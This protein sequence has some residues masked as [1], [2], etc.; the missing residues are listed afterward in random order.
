MGR[1][2]YMTISKYE[3]TNDFY[4]EIKTNSL[5]R[6]FSES[7]QGLMETLY[8]GKFPRKTAE[9][10]IRLKSINSTTLLI[11]FLNEVLSM[12]HLYKE[13][14]KNIQILSL[15]ASEVEI[16]LIGCAVDHFDNDIRATSYL[17][18][19]TQVDGKGKW[20]SKFILDVGKTI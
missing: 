5:E 9:R 10:I 4:V 2:F 20:S 13:V 17:E 15:S 6:L 8:N 18:P 11:D 3:E 12:A 7:C 16:K 14:Y 1:V 19:I